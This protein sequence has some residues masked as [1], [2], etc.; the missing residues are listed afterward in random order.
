MCRALFLARCHHVVCS[1]IFDRPLRN[2]KLDRHISQTGIF[3]FFSLLMMSGTRMQN[4]LLMKY[5]RKA[6]VN[7]FCRWSQYERLEGHLFLGFLADNGNEDMPIQDYFGCIH[8]LHLLPS[9]LRNSF[10]LRIN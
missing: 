5:Q 7:Y 3:L 10:L 2:I 6:I 4:K 9:V 8:A 1:D